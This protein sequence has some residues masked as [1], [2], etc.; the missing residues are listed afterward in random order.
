M[1]DDK[2]EKGMHPLCFFFFSFSCFDW[3]TLG[4][5]LLCRRLTIL[6][7]RALLARA[8]LLGNSD[9]LERTK[10]GKKHMGGCVC[11]LF[12]LFVV[13]F[14]SIFLF[15]LYCFAFSFGIILFLFPGCFFCWVLRAFFFTWAG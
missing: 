7:C 3:E 12:L 2:N 6:L 14:W 10:R 15:F 5:R 1:I 11:F 9:F 8:D 13:L 4:E